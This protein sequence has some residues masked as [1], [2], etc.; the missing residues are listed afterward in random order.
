MKC[1]LMRRVENRNRARDI[2]KIDYTTGKWRYE[3]LNSKKKKKKK[4]F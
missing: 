3:T 2:Q 1:S 4:N